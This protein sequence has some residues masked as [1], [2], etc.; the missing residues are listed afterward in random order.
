[1][2]AFSDSIGTDENFVAVFKHLKIT[3]EYGLIKSKKFK[4]NDSILAVYKLV[5]SQIFTTLLTLLM[6]GQ[7]P[8]RLSRSDNWTEYQR[9]PY[10]APK[11]NG[12]K[13][14]LKLCQN[15]YTDFT[16]Y[17]SIID[18][19]KSSTNSCGNANKFNFN[20]KIK[21]LSAVRCCKNYIF[22]L[23]MS[24]EPNLCQTTHRQAMLFS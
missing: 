14:F 6:L 9:S 2:E 20:V 1:M 10:A 18:T 7:D 17:I 3:K 19:M 24:G 4:V 22:S 23:N 13:S 16:R 11:H 21:R 12:L 5:C 8:A 15:V